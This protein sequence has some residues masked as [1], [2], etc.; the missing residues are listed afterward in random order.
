MQGK[1]VSRVIPG[2]FGITL[3]N[4]RIFGVGIFTVL[5]RTLKKSQLKVKLRSFQN[6]SIEIKR[7]SFVYQLNHFTVKKTH[8]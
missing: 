2:V 6:V 3:V 7:I 4:R 5:G 1:D 8:L